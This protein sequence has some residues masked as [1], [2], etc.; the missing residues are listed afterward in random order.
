MALLKGTCDIYSQ[1]MQMICY[2]LASLKCVN[3]SLCGKVDK[4]S[5][6]WELNWRGRVESSLNSEFLTLIPQ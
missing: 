3:K 6:K 2:A 4:K 5:L 1:I